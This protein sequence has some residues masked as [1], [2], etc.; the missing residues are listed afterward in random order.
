MKR[1]LALLVATVPLVVG[2]IPSSAAA[3]PLPWF[4]ANAG[5]EGSSQQLWDDTNQQLGGGKLAIRRSFDSTIK[6]SGR[7]E[8]RRTDAKRQFY[9]VKPPGNDV[10][11]FLDGEYDAQLRVTAK[12]LPSG[13]RFTVYH[14]PED[15]LSGAT[16]AK[17]M[18][19]T[20]TIVH[21]A[22]PGVEVWYVAMAYQWE[23]NAKGNVGT[24]AGW[25]DAARAADAVG[26]DVYSPGWDFGP[27]R[28]DRGFKRWWKELRVPSGK[29]WGI[30]ERGIDDS[31]GETV[32]IQTLRDDWA[33]AKE[34]GA[35][36]FLYWN[37]PRDG[38]WKLTGA[39]EQSAARAIAKEARQS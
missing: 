28:D 6:P 20:V 30:V 16:F 14:E 15:N 18:R 35:T 23:T 1:L 26:I 11:G 4:G 33:L 21:A 5:G 3:A 29:P 19:R 8:W 37:S 13:S 7:E 36:L 12:G 38:T 2:T 25:I 24:N 9:S 17:L 32:R 10:Q 39:R 27:I 22:N 34:R 31:R